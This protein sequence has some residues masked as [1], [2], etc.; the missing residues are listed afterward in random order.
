MVDHPSERFQFGRFGEAA[1]FRGMMRQERYR[2]RPKSIPPVKAS[3]TRR[4]WRNPTGPPKVKKP[5]R[6]RRGS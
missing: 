3:D 2:F 4:R 1:Q 5:R 6:K